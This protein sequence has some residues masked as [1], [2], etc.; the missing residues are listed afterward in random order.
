MLLSIII[1]NYNVK[2]FLQQCLSSVFRSDRE[3]SGGDRLELDVWVVDNDSVDGSVEM[4]RSEFPQVHVIA[5]HE[6]VGFAKANNMALALT[7]EKEK[8]AAAPEISHFSNTHFYLLLN[9]DTI[10]ESDTFV[11]CSE[12]MAKHDDCGGLCVKMVDG[13]GRYLKESKRGFPTPQAS[14]YKISGLI[15]LFPHSRCVAAYYMGHL[16]ED[17]VNEI[18]IM[19]GAFL[20]F[21]K[22]VYDKIGGLDE[23]Y[24]MY[25]EDID[26]SWRI[27]LAG[28]KNY[29]LPTTHI[30]HYKGESTKKGSMNYVYTFYNAMSIFVKRYFSGR[31]AKLFNML[32]QAA[33]WLRAGVAWLQ[34]VAKQIAVPLADF[35]AA[36]GGF[37]LLKQL[38]A[39]WWADNINYYPPQYTT[40]V[41][42]LYILTMMLCSWLQGGYDKPV[43]LNRIVRGMAFGLVLL[44]A[45]YSLLDESQRYSRMLLLGGSMWTLLST[46]LIR[47]LLDATGVKGYAMR[48]RKRGG[49]LIIG[50]AAESRRVAGMYGECK[51]G[52]EVHTTDDLSLQHLQDLVR[53]EHLEEVIFCGRDIELQRIIDLMAHLRTTGVQ[54]RIAPAEGDYI[55]G[56]GGILSAEELYIADLDTVST[57]TSRRNKRLLDMGI[58]LLTLILS[59]ILFWF[60]KRK[61]NYF[62]DS[63]NVLVGRRTWVGYTNRKGIF[64]PAD[65]NSNTSPELA[66]RLMLRYMRHYRPANDL[67]IILRNWNRI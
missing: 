54:Y 4:V 7:N 49:T 8:D 62:A 22:E 17:S 34:R 24:F 39:T 61:K 27:K 32:L 59:P 63:L 26:F 64:S 67:T 2:Y 56:A 38:W 46:L 5:N 43:R 16:D 25:G 47:L 6:N 21:R 36:Y 30:I 13:E 44:L 51:P 52:V 66:E 57:A 58:A 11:K 48:S 20:M 10:V 1:V 19:P 45:F 14:F 53:I 9:P 50:S 40:L 60:Q 31:N 42:P 33:I 35:A 15:R 55:I 29:Y 28:W 18:E 3:L 37:V 41:I 23:S 12:F 65:I